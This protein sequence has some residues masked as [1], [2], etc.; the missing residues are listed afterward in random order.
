MAQLI[1]CACCT[2][3]AGLGWY[4]HAARWKLL[5]GQKEHWSHLPQPPDARLAS[6][7][8]GIYMASAQ[9]AT[10]VVPCRDLL[11]WQ[12]EVDMLPPAPWQ[13]AAGQS[14]HHRQRLDHGTSLAPEFAAEVLQTSIG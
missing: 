1:V 2:Y 12:G 4:M 13:P 8:S 11:N 7:L 14:R 9:R 10:V 5:L 3:A 6:R